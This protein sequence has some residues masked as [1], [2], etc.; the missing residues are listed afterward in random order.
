MKP[1]ILSAVITSFQNKSLDCRMYRTCKAIG[2]TRP[3]HDMKSSQTRSPVN[4][5]GPSASKEAPEAQN[6]NVRTASPYN[7]NEFLTGA[8]IVCGRHTMRGGL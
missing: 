4:W 7:C 5:A 6:T 2:S 3:R 1:S 8:C